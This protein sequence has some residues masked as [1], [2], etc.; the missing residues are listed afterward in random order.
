MKKNMK[1][2]LS[3]VLAIFV[4][5]G[6]FAIIWFNGKNYKDF[7]AK[8]TTE[9]DIPGLSSG[10]VPQGITFDKY[11]SEEGTFLTAGYMKDGSASRIYV[12][13][14]ETTY[15]TLTIDG[16]DYVGHAGGIATYKN[17][18]YIVGDKKIHVF[19][20]SKALTLENGKSTE[21][22]K[23][24]DAPNGAD[25]INIQN[26][27]MFIGEFY[28]ETKYPTS[29]AHHIDSA[30]GKNWA[31][32]YV[33]SI[34]ENESGN[35]I[36]DHPYY[37]DVSSPDYAI[38]TTEKIQGMCINGSDNEAEIILSSSWSIAD[39]KI[40]IHQGLSNLSKVSYMYNGKDI[41]VY[42]LD[43]SNLIKTLEIPSMSEEITLYDGKVYVIFENACS[44]YKIVTRHKNKNV[45]S[46]DV[47]KFL[48]DDE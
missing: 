47:S 1:I 14:E 18:G 33:Y 25:F 46:F 3:V 42:I 13:G 22:L 24:F 4:A 39:S 26:G 45:V 43:S 31:M 21:I 23:S 35:P 11:N 37:F 5:L 48:D 41:G 36:N 7:Y 19:D 17:Y 10:Y 40:Y 8:A 12:I 34:L 2:T 27:L 29:E 38:S 16:E 32:T 20:I 9:F 44:K 28:H 15:F 30:D 6:L